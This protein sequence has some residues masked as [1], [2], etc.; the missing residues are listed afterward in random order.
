MSVGHGTA[1]ELQKALQNQQTGPP[2]VTPHIPTNTVRQAGD[3]Y[4]S[5]QNKKPANPM[6]S[7]VKRRPRP[8][9]HK[10]A[11]VH[12]HGRNNRRKSHCPHD[13]QRTTHAVWPCQDTSTKLLSTLGSTR[14][15][16]CCYSASSYCCKCPAITSDKTDASEM[17]DS[18]YLHMKS[19]A[20]KPSQQQTQRQATH[21]P[22]STKAG[23]PC[24][25]AAGSHH[26]LSTGGCLAPA[27]GTAAVCTTEQIC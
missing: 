7:G 27:V 17:T 21:W 23:Q 9:W 2:S 10:S 6:L 12:N 22:L 1:A 5:T 26:S 24:S 15:C 18:I 13:P 25:H 3:L 14:D 4:S 11:S 19:T 20:N 8:A 16:C